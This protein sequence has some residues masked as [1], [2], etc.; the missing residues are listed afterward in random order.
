MQVTKIIYILPVETGK[1]T[2]L[3]KSN[4]NYSKFVQYSLLGKL[5]GRAIYFAD[6]FRFKNNLMVNFLDPVSHNL[7]DYEIP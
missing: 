5:A 6:V 7:M 4:C 3:T 1:M 2:G